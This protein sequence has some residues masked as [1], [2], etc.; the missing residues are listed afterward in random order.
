MTEKLLIM[1]VKLNVPILSMRKGRLKILK[2]LVQIL[3]NLQ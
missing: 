1:V 3:R 2:L